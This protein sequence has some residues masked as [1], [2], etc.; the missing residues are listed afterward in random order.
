MSRPTLKLMLIEI[1]VSQFLYSIKVRLIIARVTPVRIRSE[2]QDL[3]QCAVDQNLCSFKIEMCSDEQLLRCQLTD[4]QV[5]CSCKC[6]LKYAMGL[7]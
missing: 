7:E 4:Y 2:K 6:C 5:L 1:I 3:V